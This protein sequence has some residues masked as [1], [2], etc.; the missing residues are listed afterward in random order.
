MTARLRVKLCTG[1]TESR[2][3]PL[4]K[5]EMEVILRSDAIVSI[6]N[7]NR[8]MKVEVHSPFVEKLQTCLTS[9]GMSG[10]ICSGQL[11]RHKRA[12]RKRCSH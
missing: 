1:T 12:W 5:N 10:H 6:T 4:I 11:T 3:P 8:N 2:T 7:K 9:L